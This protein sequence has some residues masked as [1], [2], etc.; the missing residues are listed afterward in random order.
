MNLLVVSWLLKEELLGAGK[1]HGL[2]VSILLFKQ[3]HD[4]SRVVPLSFLLLSSFCHSLHLCALPVYGQLES[5][6]VRKKWLELFAMP[7]WPQQFE[8]HVSWAPLQFNEREA[9]LIMWSSPIIAFMIILFVPWHYYCHECYLPLRLE[10][11]MPCSGGEQST[12]WTQVP[13]GRVSAHRPYQL[14]DSG[15]VIPPQFVRL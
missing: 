11:I 15:Q 13:G 14:G 6:A 3:L 1:L 12:S 10:D 9:R 5:L 4:S 7:K 8:C 2:R